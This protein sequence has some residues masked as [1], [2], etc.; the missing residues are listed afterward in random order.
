MIRSVCF[1]L[2]A[3]SGAIQSGG[4]MAT[5]YP[6]LQVVATVVKGNVPAAKFEGHRILLRAETVG[7]PPQLPTVPL[8]ISAIA[9]RPGAGD[10]VVFQIADVRVGDRI[11]PVRGR[12]FTATIP[13]H[14]GKRKYLPIQRGEL[15]FD[16]VDQLV[17]NAEIRVG[18]E[19]DPELA[20]VMESV[21]P[22][23]IVSAMWRAADN[24]LPRPSSKAIDWIELA[25][26]AP[27]EVNRQ[28]SLLLSREDL[29]IADRFVIGVALGD[30]LL[31]LDRFVD[32]NRAY[33]DAAKTILNYIVPDDIRAE[34]A[35]RLFNTRLHLDPAGALTG[36]IDQI[37]KS[38]LREWLTIYLR[39]Q[40]TFNQKER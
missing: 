33:E 9:Y 31:R 4:G 19:L 24:P 21:L 5:Q 8:L 6:E 10:R 32:A 1:L 25:S 26:K 40:G 3:F 22:K 38:P 29:P 34:L 28:A 7:Q 15:K 39:T 18:L 17:T 13:E 11:T 37:N 2:L 16:L 20:F 12:I 35:D 23:S 36:P 27:G 14:N 30:A